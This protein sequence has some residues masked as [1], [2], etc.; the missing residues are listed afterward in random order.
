LDGGS[1]LAIDEFENRLHPLIL[2][3][4]VLLFQSKE[5]N[6]NGAQLIFATHNTKILDF[7]ILRRDQI[8]FT[9]KTNSGSTD[10]YSLND[11]RMPNGSKTRSD[12]NYGISYIQ[13]KYGAVPFIQD[14]TQLVASTSIKKK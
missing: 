3:S 1:V 4:L 14:I 2:N 9:E 8:W 10:L 13:G 7:N 6:S 12:A 5:S 11:F